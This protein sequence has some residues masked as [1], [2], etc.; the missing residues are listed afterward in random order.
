MTTFDQLALPFAQSI[1]VKAVALKEVPFEPYQQARVLESM[2]EDIRKCCDV[3][4]P[5]FVRP[6]VSVAA[7]QQARRLGVDLRVKTWQDQHQF[8]KGRERFLLD[9]LVTVLAIREECLR[10][11]SASAIVEVLK[12][13]LSIVWILKDEDRRLSRLGYRERRDDP[14][15]AYVEAGITLLPDPL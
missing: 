2:S 7:D 5:K 11:D 4:C 10:Q 13:R 14:V 15:S 9:H 3:L 1:L 8:D 12:A 6:G